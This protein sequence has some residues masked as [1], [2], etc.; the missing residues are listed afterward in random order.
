MHSKENLCYIA[1]LYS[2]QY[3]CDYVEVIAVESR[4]SDIGTRCRTPGFVKRVR[5]NSPGG[6]RIFAAHMNRVEIMTAA[7]IAHKHRHFYQR[8]GSDRVCNRDKSVVHARTS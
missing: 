6:L 4:K 8:A 7:V 5:R 2:V 3:A 1:L